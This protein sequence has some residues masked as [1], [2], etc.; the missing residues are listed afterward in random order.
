MFATIGVVSTGDRGHGVGRAL[1]QGG[2]RAITALEGRSARSR[3]LAEAGGIEDVGSLGKLLA[4]ADLVL[5]IMP[6]AE[7][8]GFARQ[9]A[10]AMRGQARRPHFADMNAVSPATAQEIGKVITGAGAVFSDGGIVGASP[11][12]GKGTGG[13]PTGL[14]T[15]FYVS[16]PQA[17]ALTALDGNGILVKPMGP[18]IG[19][20]SGMKM[21]YSAMNKGALGL[22]AT[23]LLVAE[24][25]GLTEALMAELGSSQKQVH[26]RVR[27]SIG[28]LATDAQR[29]IGEMEEIAATFAAA[30][31]S[32]K[33]FE[34]AE[35]IYRLLA[36]TPLA[37][38]KRETADRSRSLEASLKIFAA[39]LDGRKAAE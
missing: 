23:T 13:Q 33:Y 30:G 31:L 9:A 12:G 36:A 15:R 19:R 14:P 3:K 1:K 25:L 20:A 17:Q 10:Q 22:Y 18:E 5:S 11:G 28:W 21:V 34:G 39:S 2:R 4:E 16:G 6:P 24:R 7:A 26:D 35:D 32:P 8:L 37:A 29:W 38:E 27:G